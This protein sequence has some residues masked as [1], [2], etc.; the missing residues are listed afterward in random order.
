[1]ATLTVT[2]VPD[3]VHRALRARAAENGRSVEAEVRVIL[4]ESL[5]P[6][7]RVRMGDG[8]AALG[9]ELGLAEEDFEVFGQI[10][11]RKQSS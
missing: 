5:N 4:E 7:G 6:A 8:L 3:D 2:N 10:R 11:D 1:M 9:R